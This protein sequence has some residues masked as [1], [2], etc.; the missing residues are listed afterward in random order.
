MALKQLMIAR[1]LEQKRSLLGGV[2]TA[3]KEIQTRESELAVA[4]E[5]ATTDAEFTT[6]EDEAK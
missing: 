6:V 2:I 1:K 4:I 5:E 3:E